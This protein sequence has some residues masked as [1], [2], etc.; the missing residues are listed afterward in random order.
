[1]PGRR[2]PT[3]PPT[4]GTADPR[5]VTF[6][7]VAN[8]PALKAGRRGILV[9][10]SGV[11][12]PQAVATGRVA[13]V[14]DSYPVRGDKDRCES[15]PEFASGRSVR[16]RSYDAYHDYSRIIDQNDGATLAEYHVNYVG[17]TGDCAR[18]DLTD[19]DLYQ[20]RSNRSDFS[21]DQEVVKNGQKSQW[22]NQ[23]RL[24]TA[25]AEPLAERQ[26]T[27]KK[28]TADGSGIACIVFDMM[29]KPGGFVRVI[30][31]ERRQG[32]FRA[33]ELSWSWPR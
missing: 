15:F 2:S 23:F 29:L 7:Y 31:L 22:A 20:N 14:R 11:E 27:I 17:R 5:K 32:L 6:A 33:E 3:S 18:S 13:L 28:Y 16:I 24:R 26:V 19:S 10:K 12:G 9:I 4:S 21:F 30:D 1:M 8:E 25:Y